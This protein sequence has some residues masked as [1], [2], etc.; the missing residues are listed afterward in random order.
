MLD[1]EHGPFAF[2]FARFAKCKRAIGRGKRPICFPITYGIRLGFTTIG[3]AEYS[4]GWQLRFMSN[5]RT[6]KTEPELPTT[7]PAPV[8]GLRTEG[9]LPNLER[10]VASWNAGRVP[11]LFYAPDRTLDDCAWLPSGG[12]RSDLRWAGGCV[13]FVRMTRQQVTKCADSMQWVC[14]DGKGAAR[15]RWLR[16]RRGVGAPRLLVFC[17]R[18]PLHLDF[19]HE[20]GFTPAPG[21]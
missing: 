20:N 6:T 13:E 9:I 11:A 1:K 8:D 12:L 7:A 5:T 21:T 17:N 14:T 19:D 10:I 15:A 16:R 3:L 4:Q 2:L 18:G